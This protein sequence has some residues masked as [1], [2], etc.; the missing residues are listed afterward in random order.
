MEQF[1]YSDIF[2]TK[3]IEYIVVISF[4]LLII[5]V[6]RM[7]SKPVRQEAGS[8][9]AIQALTLKA[10][11]IPQGLLFNKNHTWSHLE[12]SGLA[13]VGID[14]MLLHL[15]G[16]VELT[17]L[18]Q[19][20]ERVKR[21]EAIARISRE[22]K[23]LVISSPISGKIDRV[24]A[25]LEEDSAAI[26]DDP[27]SSWLYRIKPEKW[28]EE[29]NKAM[30]AEGATEWLEKELDR[31]RDYMA[32]LVNAS[33]GGEVLMQTGGE[34]IAHPLAEMDREG[35]NGFQKKFLNI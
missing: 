27:Y 19:R 28:K 33:T 30:M 14:D 32:G 3:G 11:R 31:F 24:H 23:E 35:W 12:K 22:G 7:L 4:L 1:T 25:S 29:T 20:E 13:S 10:L 5:P 26:I 21:G 9:K 6:W 16:G 2:E 8:G 15:T 18:K 17:Y 34:F